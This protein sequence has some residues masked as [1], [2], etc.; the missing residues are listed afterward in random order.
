[1][2][3]S[4]L[5]LFTSP[6]SVSSLLAHSNYNTPILHSF[7][8]PLLTSQLQNNKTPT[9]VK[10][11]RKTATNLP[12]MFTRTIINLAALTAST[13]A[14]DLIIQTPASL[15][16]CQPVLLNWSGGQG[17]LFAINFSESHC[18]ITPIVMSSSSRP[19]A[20]TFELKCR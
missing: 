7:N 12:K 18:S 8:S 3:K 9:R 10:K 13:V 16:E 11:E 15:I 4:S 14:G 5:T 2:Y 1:M 19:L 17:T 6:H 20:S